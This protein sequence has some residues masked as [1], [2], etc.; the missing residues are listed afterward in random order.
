MRS[1]RG[2]ASGAEHFPKGQYSRCDRDAKIAIMSTANTTARRRRE[3]GEPGSST[4]SQLQ[5]YRRL[6]TAIEGMARGKAEPKT[7]AMLCA[8][9]GVSQRTLLRAFRAVHG[10]SVHRRLQSIRLAQAR[11]MLTS[12]DA[13]S[14]TVTEIAMRC[15]FLELGRF[16]LLYRK[17]FGETPSETLNRAMRARKLDQ[18]PSL[19][20]DVERPFAHSLLHKP[21][22]V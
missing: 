12:T 11:S 19:S 2:A 3:A 4:P 5:R 1:A 21:E 17:T 10:V 14:T 18:S 7:V 15:G 16:S 20:D 13:E 6:V 8:A 9:A 22:R